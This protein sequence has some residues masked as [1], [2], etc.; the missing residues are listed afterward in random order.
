V[1]PAPLSR[2]RGRGRKNSVHLG[3]LQV[4]NQRT[5]NF[6]NVT[7]R[8][9]PL[10]STSSGA[11]KPTN[12]ANAW[13]AA[14]R[15]F[16]VATLHPRC[17]SI[18]VRNCRTRS[19]DRPVTVNRS[20]GFR[21]H[22]ATAGSNTINGTAVTTTAPAVTVVTGPISLAKSPVSVSAA[23]MAASGTVT[24]TFQ[25]E[26]AGGNKLLLPGQTVVFSLVS[27][28]TFGPTTY[29]SKMGA[30]SATFTTT[31]AGADHVTAT[32]NGQAVTSALAALTVTPGAASPATSLVSVAS[33]IVAS[34]S[35]V[36]VTLRAVDAYGN[37]EIAGGLKVAFALAI[38]TGGQGKFG[39]VTDMKDGTCTVTFTGTTAGTNTITA[40]IG[41]KAV[42][43]TAPTITVTPGAYRLATSVVTLS[44]ASVAPGGTVTVYLQT[45]DAAGNDLTPNLL[46]DG[47]AIS[48]F[49]GTTSG[50]EGTFTAATSLGNGDY[51][52]TFTATSAGT[53]TI[54]AEI[55]TGKV[56]STAP[57]ITVT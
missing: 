52:A 2:G 32:W 40:T 30:Y 13:I 4:R 36:V 10:H 8:T 34:G 41:G 7:F 49:F 18:S 14:G 54:M 55:G 12:R 5:G 15:W 25:P 11:C 56:T 57:K 42:T 3:L 1:I 31:A 28:S 27:G 44:A 45:K 48:F 37:P 51:E 24:V 21:V 50:H 33:S 6:L 20:S 16:G 47:I 22:P 38:K 39:T 53:N 43:S 9:C 29:N 17:S 26:D 46:A 23:S 19:A 35:G